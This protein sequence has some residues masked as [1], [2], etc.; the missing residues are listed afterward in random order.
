CYEKGIPAVTAAPL[1]MGVAFLSFLPGKMSFED[2]FQMEGKPEQEQLLSFLVG[3]SPSMLQLGYLVDESRVDFHARK[4]PSTG[5]ACELCAGV[6][7]TNALKI[8]LN[9]GD[10]IA[11]P[12]GLHFDAF[13]N[14][15]KKTWRPGGNSNPMQK[16]MLM[17]ARKKVSNV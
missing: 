17:V 10:V 2:Y 6:A 14:K 9:R 16:L 13:R 1:G 12:W 5:M 4:G 7:A 11:A 15:M 3:L 8:L